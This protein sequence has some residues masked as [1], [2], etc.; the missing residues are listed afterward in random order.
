MTTSQTITKIA[1]ALLV[2]QK[3]IGSAKKD[4]ENPFF[5]STYADLGSVIEA[6]KSALNDND[7]IVLQP[8]STDESGTYV[9]TVLL[10][11]SGEWIADKLKISPK[12]D[13]D[14]QS[15]GSAISYCRRYGLQSMVLIPSDDDDGEKTRT[16]PADT[17][18]VTPPKLASD[19]QVKLISV[20]LDK[21]GQS[22]E[23]LKLKYKVKSKKDLTSFQA[24]TI[25][26]NLNKL[27]DITDIPEIDIDEIDKVIK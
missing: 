10:H 15:V 25:I 11:T 23:D 6:C 19:K 27:P 17:K 2:A 5:H 9:E 21:K 14:Q 8:I 3:K 24:S 13:N 18:P 26:E 1:P 22:N 20:L 4:A 16:A 12:N 7:I